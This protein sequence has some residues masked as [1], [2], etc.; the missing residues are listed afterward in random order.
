VPRSLIRRKLPKGKRR[1][2]KEVGRSTM[3]YDARL[4]ANF[5][6]AL[7]ALRMTHRISRDEVCVSIGIIWTRLRDIENGRTGI[8]VHEWLALAKLYCVDALELL[9]FARTARRLFPPIPE[10]RFRYYPPWQQRSRNGQTHRTPKLATA[11]DLLRRDS[12]SLV[13]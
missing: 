13:R 8:K 11:V 7:F 9:A 6:H 1:V 5:G 3:R 10:Q 2:R 12:G 4:A